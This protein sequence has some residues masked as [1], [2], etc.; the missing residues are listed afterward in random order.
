MADTSTGEAC[1]PRVLTTAAAAEAH[2]SPTRSRLSLGVQRRSA[3]TPTPA[4]VPA[5]MPASMHDDAPSADASRALPPSTN[6]P[7]TAPSR[8]KRASAWFGRDDAALAQQQHEQQQQP[9][10]PS[11]S[12][13][14]QMPADMQATLALVNSALSSLGAQAITSEEAALLVRTFGSATSL[15]TS[16]DSLQRSRQRARAR[17]ATRKLPRFTKQELTQAEAPAPSIAVEQL[18]PAPSNATATDVTAAAGTITA[19]VASP[20]EPCQETTQAREATPAVA[21]PTSSVLLRVASASSRDQVRRRSKRIE[22]AGGALS[23]APNAA[24]TPQPSP[25]AAEAASSPVAITQRTAS[26]SS[27]SAR[28]ATE[29][30]QLIP[31]V[32]EQHE[33]LAFE[34]RRARLAALVP[35]TQLALFNDPTPLEQEIE[36]LRNALSRTLQQV[37]A[38]EAHAAA[39]QRAFKARVSDAEKRYLGSLDDNLELIRELKLISGLVSELRG[40][41]AHG[42]EQLQ[43]QSSRAD[44]AERELLE[45]QATF[46]ARSGETER[47]LAALQVA[48]AQANE[49]AESY[50][51]SIEELDR[52]N[53]SHIESLAQQLDVHVQAAAS[54]QASIARL[55]QRNAELVAEVAQLKLAEQLRILREQKQQQQQQ[56]PPQPAPELVET[57]SNRG[58]STS[59]QQQQ[60][61]EQMSDRTQQLESQ[62][63]QLEEAH[64]QAM[65]QLKESNSRVLRL[66]GQLI[67][68]RSEGGNKDIAL[69][70]AQQRI[71]SL[72]SSTETLQASVVTLTSD[73]EHARSESIA[74]QQALEHARRENGELR[75]ALEQERERCD[76]QQR[77]HEHQV[78]QLDEH[79]QQL[80]SRVAHEADK[81][82]NDTAAAQHRIGQLEQLA[83]STSKHLHHAQQ[84]LLQSQEECSRVHQEM[85]DLQRRL[86]LAQHELS[87]LQQA[88]SVLAPCDESRLDE[89]EARI[90]TPT[91]DTTTATHDD[92]PPAVPVV[93]TS[94]NNSDL[95][96]ITSVTTSWLPPP[97]PPVAAPSIVIVPEMPIETALPRDCS[98]D[99]PTDSP[100]L[101]SPP[102]P[103]PP[104]A[105]PTTAPPPPPAPP[106]T[107]P[108]PLDPPAGSLVSLLSRIR[109]GVTL[110]HQVTSFAISYWLVDR[111][112]PTLTTSLC[113]L[114]PTSVTKEPKA[115]SLDD[116]SILTIIAQA[117][118]R[119]RARITMHDDDDDE[120]DDQEDS[121]FDDADEDDEAV[122]IIDDDDDGLEEYDDG[123]DEDELYLEDDGD[124]LDYDDGELSNHDARP[125]VHS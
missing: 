65:Q 104:P 54:D 28:R 69:S 92:E 22:T 60:M 111:V 56:A 79:I 74:R 78:R 11:G 87:R 119:R 55:E 122:G 118:I 115:P 57:E 41:L 53:K 9:P 36:L 2:T 114:Q 95:V 63:G 71:A 81:T 96:D 14:E 61:I 3:V 62:L 72:E 6:N 58:A 39:K 20:S 121:A 52:I 27:S 47:Q 75:L 120:S 15:S 1:V 124:E 16:G 33:L 112:D 125:T 84:D 44:K 101:P 18:A 49:R 98:P 40:R 25:V 64:R 30:R 19:A 91:C 106:T 32:N 13:L 51:L 116:Q 109:E 59:E 21:Q 24:P 76:S 12:A 7:T 23:A 10:P 66:E 94:S 68:V 113:C 90:V 83:S 108:A 17:A 4:S 89:A 93:V 105:P 8:R 45:L 42:D 117:L 29:R 100:K 86:S 37:E 103:A 5:S 80:E 48:T 34:T 110:R 67:L 26:K 99:A 50:R 107:Q 35:R 70:R 97:P 102:S 43:A 123:N 85:A 38:L 46:D 31:N 77:D 82:R 88:S 73:L